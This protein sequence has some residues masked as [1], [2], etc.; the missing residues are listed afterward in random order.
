MKVSTSLVS[1]VTHCLVL[2]SFY[3]EIV[4]PISLDLLTAAAISLAVLTLMGSIKG[5]FTKRA[6]DPAYYGGAV[7]AAVVF[8]LVA[9]LL[10]RELENP[11]RE[12]PALSAYVHTIR[13]SEWLTVMT[14]IIA[15]P[16]VGWVG[17]RIGRNLRRA[18]A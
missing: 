15:I 5:W 7:V 6:T 17:V 9:L 3:I 13:A 8:V 11:V 1:L 14:S 12:P 2:L 16:V 10:K 4:T 18:L